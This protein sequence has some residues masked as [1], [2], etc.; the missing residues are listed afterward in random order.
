[1]NNAIYS[2]LNDRDGNKI[3][4]AIMKNM[5]RILTALLLISISAIAFAANEFDPETDI[6][7]THFVN[8]GELKDGD[9]FKVLLSLEVPNDYHITDSDLFYVDIESAPDY[10]FT[11]KIL[12]KK[13]KHNELPTYK[14]KVDILLDGTYKITENENI[15]NFGY[16]I[17]SELGDESCFMPVDKELKIDFSLIDPDVFKGIEQINHK[18][19]AGEI[20]EQ[21]SPETSIFGA[22]FG[23]DDEMTIEEK[24]A[25]ILEGSQTW[26]LLVFLIAFLGGML[27]SMTPC[28][29]PIIPVVISYMG[30]KSGSKKSA[31]FFLSLFFVIGLA[32]T[33]SIVGLLASFLGGMFG[34]GDLAANPIVRVGIAMVFTVLALSMFG[35]WDMNLISSNQQTKLMKKGK[36][37]K[38]I[39]GAVLIGMVSG[40]VAAP[41]VGPVL[42]VLLM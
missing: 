6:M 10:S 37:S 35:L 22:L 19:E 17:C 32:I 3:K 9:Q 39:L 11:T 27:D 14:G 41:C 20:T 12:T 8:K 33:Y 40:V 21:N 36:E 16:Q 18:G 4:R 2:E 1:M 7:I 26:T 25:G 23:G 42:A 5:M 15:V 30:A 38:G 28:V 13:I 29:Y 31:G 24:L 34:V